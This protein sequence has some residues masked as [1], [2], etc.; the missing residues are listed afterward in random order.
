MYRVILSY[1]KFILSIPLYSYTLNLRMLKISNYKE[2]LKL[3][4]KS[5]VENS[6]Q[7]IVT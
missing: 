1:L 2:T 4:D 6:F 7:D 5:K 3:T